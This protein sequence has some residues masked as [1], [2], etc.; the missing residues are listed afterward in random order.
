MFHSV[1][2]PFP[3]KFLFRLYHPR[4]KWLIMLFHC[5]II[6][7]QTPLSFSNIFIEWN[8]FYSVIHICCCTGSFISA[9]LYCSL[10]SSVLVILNFSLITVCSFF[11]LNKKPSLADG[12]F[13]CW[14]KATSVKERLLRKELLNPSQVH[15]VFRKLSCKLY[16]Y[17]FYF[18]CRFS[19]SC[20]YW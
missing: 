20:L 3:N 7:L 14:R 4:K 9:C 19:I 15:S 8:C 16:W 6:H 13:F 2:L 18:T 10:N 12:F 17:H 11:P 1:C 5:G